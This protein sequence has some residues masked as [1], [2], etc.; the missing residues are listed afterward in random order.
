MTERTSE[1]DDFAAFNEEF[2]A[3]SDRAIV[4]L[5]AAKLDYLLL[6]VLQKHLVPDTATNDEFFENQG[7]GSTFSNKIALALRLGLISQ[8]VTQRLTLIRRIR[9]DFAH[10]IT[11]SSL[12]AGSHRD[13]VP[14]SVDAAPLPRQRTTR[15]GRRVYWFPG[16]NS[17]MR[18]T[19][20]TA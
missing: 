2:S 12:E 16:A 15:R 1:L 6:C 8:D 5:T 9:N 7:P 17:E 14:A 18:P 19:A 10:E 20:P 4:V 3:E 13:R 11:G